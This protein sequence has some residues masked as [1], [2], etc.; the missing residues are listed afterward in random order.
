MRP[1]VPLSRLDVK[2]PKMSRWVDAM[3]GQ[4][5]GGGPRVT[6]G[7]T[8]FRWLR[9]QLLMVEDYTYAGTNFREDPDLPLLD[10]VE[11]DDRGKK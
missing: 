5:N 7:P 11:M 6:Y 10:G 1:Q 4:H 9:S 3:A 8:F 2:D